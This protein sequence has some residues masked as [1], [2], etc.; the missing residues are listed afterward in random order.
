MTYSL[1]IGSDLHR[2]KTIYIGGIVD[3]HNEQLPIKPLLKR[4]LEKN[5]FIIVDAA[6]EA[7][8]I[9]TGSILSELPLDGDG[10]ARPR[11]FP[12]F[13]LTAPTGEVLWAG[14]TKFYAAWDNPDRL[15]IAASKIA[16]KLFND[17]K[18]SA[19]LVGIKP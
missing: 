3:D 8:A 1:A 2:I 14:A 4:E 13:K 6:S 19:K 17:W 12:D 18:R 5:G 9:L 10:T 16:K 15:Q 11:F 7:D